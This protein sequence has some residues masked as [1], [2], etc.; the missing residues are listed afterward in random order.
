MLSTSNPQTPNTSNPNPTKLHRNRTKHVAL[1]PQRSPEIRSSFLNKNKPQ[2][3]SAK[4]P[5]TFLF[6]YDLYRY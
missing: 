6:R 5:V 3:P 1:K 2:K 4:S